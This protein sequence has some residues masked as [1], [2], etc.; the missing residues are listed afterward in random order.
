MPRTLSFAHRFVP[1]RAGS[2]VL[3]LLHGTG[4]D[5]DD[6]LPLGRALDP[7]A[8]LLS[9]RGKV[10]ERG[11]PRFFRRI[12]EGVFDVEDLKLRAGELAEFV[13]EAGEAYGFDP[14]RVVAAGFSNG[15]NIA[16]AVLLLHPRALAAAALFSPMV[17]L[18]PEP[19]PDLAG[20]N[21][22]IGAGRLDPIAPPEQ[23]RALEALLQECGA[24]VT[25]H[26]TDGGHGI[27][28]DEVDS[29]RAWLAS[30]PRP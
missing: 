22:W 6:L 17:P 13:G 10:L 12:A 27:T 23:V 9:P 14:G 20:V 30:L 3:L 4:G 7:E 24:G 11:M 29:A 18:D 16:A 28:P 5:E 8:A 15:A 25:V 2:R 1:G 19:R 26:W 21:A